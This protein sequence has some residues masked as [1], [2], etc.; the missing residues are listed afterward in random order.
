M[1]TTEKVLR[2]P[3]PWWRPQC[4]SEE[5]PVAELT[6]KQRANV[7]ALESGLPDI[8]AGFGFVLQSYTCMHVDEKEAL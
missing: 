7:C 8:R 2:C 3:G 5:R 6:E 4:L 1:V